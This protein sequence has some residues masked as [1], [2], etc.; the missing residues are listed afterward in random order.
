MHI[1]SIGLH[2]WLSFRSVQH[3]AE[4]SPQH[5]VIVGRNGAGKTNFFNAISFVLGDDYSNMGAAA[6]SELLHTGA[7]A[8]VVRAYVEI[9]F[10]NSDGASLLICLLLKA[11]ADVKNCP[12]TLLPVRFIISSPCPHAQ[13]AAC[14]E[15]LQR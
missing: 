9:V 8:S 3:L 10:D 4:F 5:N 11:V 6:R 15:S 2:G 14:Q 1:K 12:R 7:G 13:Q